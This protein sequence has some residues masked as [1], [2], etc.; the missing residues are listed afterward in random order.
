M[1]IYAYENILNNLNAL[2]SPLQNSISLLYYSFSLL[3]PFVPSHN[4]SSLHIL[5]VGE[6]RFIHLPGMH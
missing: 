2:I 5:Y 4:T 3:I 6:S 1:V